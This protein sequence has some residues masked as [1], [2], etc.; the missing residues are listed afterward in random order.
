MFSQRESEISGGRRIRHNF[1]D[2]IEVILGP[3]PFCDLSLI[4]MLSPAEV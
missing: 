4:A 1:L 2:I 3:K